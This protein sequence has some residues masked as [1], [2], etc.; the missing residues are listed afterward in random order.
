MIL[1]FS[2]TQICVVPLVLT[3]V[4]DRVSLW[5]SDVMMRGAFVIPSPLSSN[6]EAQGLGT[7]GLWT[8]ASWLGLDPG[9]PCHGWSPDLDI[10]PDI[11]EFQFFLL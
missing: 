4:E 10:F 9:S 8:T 2:I 1:P 7:R 5:G 11:A 3:F 6:S